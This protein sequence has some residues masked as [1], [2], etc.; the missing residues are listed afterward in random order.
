MSSFHHLQSL[1]LLWKRLNKMLK[2]LLPFPFLPFRIFNLFRFLIGP[3]KQEYTIAQ[4]GSDIHC[5]ERTCP[6]L[7]KVEPMQIV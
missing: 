7:D 3:P 2:P 5:T 1:L 6:N 4:C